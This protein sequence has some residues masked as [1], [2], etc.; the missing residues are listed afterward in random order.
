LQKLKDILQE[1]LQPGEKVIIFSQFRDS[2]ESIARVLNTLDH[3][4]AKCFVGQTKKGTSG[5][6]QKQQI[7]LLDQFRD[8]TF[9]V[10]VATSVAE[11]G[12]DIPKV[13]YVIFYE[14]IP[15]AIRH[16]QRRGRTGRSEKGEVI[17]LVTEQTRDEAY[18]WSAFH[19]EKKM[20]RI[21]DNLRSKL[22]HTLAKQ[23][24][25]K[26]L[27][28]YPESTFTIYTDYREKGS[29]VMK[30]LLDQG[31]DI[32]LT[33]LE[34]ADY[35]LS[36]RVGVEFKTVEDFVN[37]IIDG[38]L[39]PQVKNLKE[40][41][42]RP[43]IVIEG[44]EDIYQVRKVHANA[45]RGMLATISIDFVIPILQTANPMETAA[46]FTIIAKREQEK[47]SRDFPLHTS[48]KPLSLTEQQE[49]LI[50]ALPGIGPTLAKP[51]LGQFGSVR[52]IVNA[53]EEEL[54]NVDLIGPV[55]AKT[56]RTVIDREYEDSPNGNDKTE[57]K[58]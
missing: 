58:N 37:S 35:V 20:Y 31:V 12:L 3:V 36:S 7:E 26:T 32:R 13:D 5:L 46:L 48:K 27:S 39:L 30:R 6:S 9:N 14:P 1:R 33:R 2:V 34:S 17:V 15:S 55:K 49:Y 21:L 57:N 28:S 4:Q 52:S 29:A 47:I 40:N 23:K 19:K 54:K 51:L 18:R 25:Q 38:R 16:I 53:T 8:N 22:V 44:K 43:M 42:E 24:P 45:I 41:F 10:L 50:S 11:E 56:I